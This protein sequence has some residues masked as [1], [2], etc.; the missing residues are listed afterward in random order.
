MYYKCIMKVVNEKHYFISKSLYKNELFLLSVIESV[1]ISKH[2]NMF[3]SFS[4][5]LEID[6]MHVLQSAFFL[7]K[8]K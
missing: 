8:Q 1:Q 3:L 5:A 7:I 6:E 2:P 4:A